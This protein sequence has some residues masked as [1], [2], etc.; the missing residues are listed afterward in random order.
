MNHILRAQWDAEFRAFEES[1]ASAA[2]LERLTAWAGREQLNERSSETAFIQRFFVET[3]GYRLQGHDH[4]DTAF[5]CL[6]QFEVAGGGIKAA[7]T[8]PGTTN[9]IDSLDSFDSLDR[10]EKRSVGSRRGAW[11]RGAR[12]F[13]G[14]FF[15]CYYNRNLYIE[16]FLNGWFSF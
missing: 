15:G 9:C 3:W 1:P 11:E 7:K 6:P 5:T 12:V 4:A 16:G 14:V 2:L 10:I 8:P 13:F